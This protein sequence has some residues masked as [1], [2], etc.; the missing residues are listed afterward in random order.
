MGGQVAR[1]A[2]AD[3]GKVILRSSVG[4]EEQKRRLSIDVTYL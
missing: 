2:L 1:V 3:S 4:Y